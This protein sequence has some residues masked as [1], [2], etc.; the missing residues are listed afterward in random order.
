MKIVISGAAQLG[1]LFA[2]SYCAKED[3][4]VIE[5]DE[6]NISKV[7]K[8]DVQV[9]R[10]N[11]S[12]LST[13]QA[14]EIGKADIFIAC[15]HS[16]ELNIIS[17]LAVKQLSNAAT[18]CFVNKINYFE[19]FAGELGEKLV[20]D[21]II[22]PEQLLGKY[23]GQIISVP[24]AIDVKMFSHENLKLLEFRLK[25]G[26][27]KIGKSLKDVR[28][29]KGTLAV[30]VF[31]NDSVIIPDGSTRFEK[32][33]KII[34]MGLAES[35]RKLENRFMKNEQKRPNIIVVGGGNVGSI[36]AQYLSG[37]A[38]VRLIENS[39]QRCMYLAEALPE[40]ILV[41][42][43]D[44]TDPNV[45]KAQQIETADCLVAVT[46]S[47]ERNLFVS[48]HAKTTG[49]KRIITRAHKIEN[50]DFFEA[51]GIDVAL[52]S[53][54]N[55]IHSVTK[56]ISTENVDVFTF[57]EKGK[58]EIREIVVPKEFPAT[59]LMNL[60]LPAGVIIAAI[61]RGGRTIV[62]HGKRQA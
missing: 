59:E 41:M 39:Y 14:A 31:R 49:V 28:L 17:C 7:E 30:A 47:D 21:Q 37:C 35:I 3:V 29:P 34:F 42:N 8:L 4:F 23:I 11:P 27:D 40:D 53:Q 18:Y 6:Q 62:P 16:D 52:S 46:G 57:F 20:I 38:R 55:A 45:L 9:I 25:E 54:L 10:G 2:K 58:A 36:V 56:A 61:R 1:Y 43:A 51:L 50:I 32:L 48:M 60:H 13:L 26:D 44:G 12:S 15:N 24:G 5:S 22:W 33:D 19:T